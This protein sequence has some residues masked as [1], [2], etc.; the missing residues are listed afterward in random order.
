MRESL[1]LREAADLTGVASLVEVLR[2]TE[3]DAP[4]VIRRTQTERTQVEGRAQG[5]GSPLYPE[6]GG[7][8]DAHE[9]VQDILA[10]LF[11]HPLGAFRRLRD[12]ALSAGQRTSLA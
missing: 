11:L 6:A 5:A 10:E 2:E 7:N 8:T 4:R 3:A 9:V 12:S 1:F